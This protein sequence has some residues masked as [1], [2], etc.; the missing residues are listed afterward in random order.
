MMRAPSSPLPATTG[1]LPLTHLLL[2]CAVVAVWGTNFVVIHHGLRHFPPFLFAALRFLFAAIPAIFFLPRPALPWRFTILY[3]LFIGVGQFGL[4]YIA[5]T[6]GFAPGLASLVIQAQVFF[7]IALSIVLARERIRPT[8]VIA[9]LLCLVGLGLIAARSEGASASLGLVLVLL[10]ALSWACGNQVARSAGKVP[11]L[12]FVVWSSLFAF[13][14]LAALSLVVEGPMRIGNSLVAATPAAWSAL[15]WQSVGNTLFG[16][17]AWAW[18]LS[19]HPA[20]L[21]TPTALLVPV[22]GMS[23]SALLLREPM[24]AWKLTAAALVVAGLMIN[25]LAPRFGR[26]SGPQDRHFESRNQDGG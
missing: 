20:A 21:I 17:A 8:Q 6:H 16:Y 1:G 18:L 7:T 12:P 3:G 24:Q 2:A 23:A 22:F 5:L 4:L 26:S 19:R 9:L 10:A 25:S 11:M 13:P 14:P 15:L